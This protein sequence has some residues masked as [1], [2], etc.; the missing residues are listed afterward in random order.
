MPQRMMHA[1]PIVGAPVMDIVVW[2]RSLGLGKYEAAFR[3]NDIDET[4]LPGLTHETLKELGVA[5]IG[6]RVKLLDA[7][8]A[9]RSDASGKTPSVD[10]TTT[11]SAPS[12]HPEDRAERRQVT[13]MFSDLVGSTALSARLDPEDLREVISAYQNC[14]AETVG[15]LG[16]FIAKFMGDGVLVYFGYPHAHEDDAERAVRAGLELVATVGQLKTHATLQTRVG[17]ATGLVVVGDLIG[18]G[19]SQEQAIVGE[20]P[21]LAARLQSV[22]EPNNVVIAESSRKLVGNLFEVE[23]LGAK[24]LKGISGSVRCWVALRPASVESRFEALHASG[25]TELVGRDE[26]LDLLLRRWL[27]AKSGE[28]QVVLLSGEAGIGKSRLTA[29]LLER[30]S[31]EPHTRLRYFCSP[32][33]TD[34]AFYPI[35][36]QMERAA[37]F[38]HND[39]T[40]AKLD[41][42]DAVLAQSFTARPDAAL[43]AEMLSLPNDGRYPTLELAPQ[44]RRQRTLEAL[45]GQLEALSRSSPVLMMFEDVHWIDPTSLEAL[46]RAVDRIRTLGALLIVTY[47]PEFEPPWIG[48]P[49]VSAVIL[50][51]LGEREI[52]SMIDGVTGNKPL[53]ESIRQDIIERTD[54]IPLFVEEMTK[55]VLEA[56]GEGEAQHTAASVPSSAL[57]VPASLHASLMARLDR[58]GPTKEVAQIG[59]AI[60]RDFSHPLLAAVVRKPEAEL[61][62]ALDRLIASGLLFRQGVPPHATYLFK[63]ALVQD[64]AYGTLLREP[65]RAL[66][67]RIAETLESQFADVVERQPELLARHCTEA[68]LIDKAARLWGKAGQRSLERSALVEASEQITRALAQI[69]ALPATPALRREQIKLQVALITPLIHIKGYAA[70]ETKAAEERARLLIEQAEALGEPPEDPLLLFSVLYGFWVANYVAFNG[71]VVR[72]RAAQFLALAEKQTAIVPL[73][74]GHRLMGNSLLYTGDIAQ[75]RAH[76]DQAMALYDPAEHRPLAMRFGQDAGMTM[77]VIRS[78]G[79]WLLGYPEAAS[80]DTDRA[81]ED[82]RKIGQAATLMHALAN[83][84]ATRIHCGNYVAANAEADEV[85]ALAEQKSAV[86]WKAFGMMNKG[87]VLALTGRASDAV[88]LM[89]SGITAYRTTGATVFIPWWLPQLAR[90]YAELG[91]FDDAWRCIGEA[92]T[93]LETT[94]EK[95]WEAEVN[96]MAGHIALIST[97][98]DVAQAEMYFERALAVAR[99]QQAKSWELRAAMSMARLWRNQGKV[100]QARELLAPIYGWFTEGHNTRDL[101]EAKALLEELAA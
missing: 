96:R 79:L 29:A 41:K 20:T 39:T 47:R 44:E 74:I 7:I 40:E 49:H 6:H 33:H 17:I 76:Y 25:L 81:L 71:D 57:A 30:L 80:A 43:F 64:A 54:G 73:M 68:E 45:T 2:L 94:K 27:K 38:A 51:R 58:L 62:S 75:G 23:E 101:K 83:A 92:I 32:Q 100:Q 50:N 97:E 31:S 89:T 86:Y 87:C 85:V 26:E 4:V 56:E 70:P 66:H 63:H 78:W 35:I 12:A 1:T 37:G 42:L 28:G 84:S 98:A 93:A 18:S 15:R 11:S 34:S 53:P 65:R 22:A 48:R 55:A 69:A 21:N 10:A 9:L 72:E 59:A 24:E 13:V 5:S 16:G 99:Q 95:C 14:V 46:G 3:E 61:V 8:A 60:G 82:A 52:A 91:Q 90:A 77:L 88:Q 19:A 36:G 67:A